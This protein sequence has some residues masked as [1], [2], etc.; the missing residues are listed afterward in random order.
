MRKGWD[1]SESRVLA[2]PE[3]I[4]GSIVIVF[5]HRAVGEGGVGIW[6]VGSHEHAAA[7]LCAW[8]GRTHDQFEGS[9][10]AM[11]RCEVSFRIGN[12]HGIV[13]LHHDRVPARRQRDQV[14]IHI[15][16][17]IITLSIC[18]L[19]WQSPS[20][21]RRLCCLLSMMLFFLESRYRSTSGLAGRYGSRRPP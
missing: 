13:V 15:Q 11:M 4:G 6:A 20:P 7:E 18:E 10:S 19:L 2:S 9:D 16:G 8:R 12:T 1:G 17:G 3:G 5:G 14:V 21:M